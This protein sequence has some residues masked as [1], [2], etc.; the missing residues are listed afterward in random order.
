MVG[1]ES[2]AE[3]IDVLATA[4][5][6]RMTVQQIEALDLAYAPPLAPVYD[7]VLV[8]ASVAKKGLRILVRA[9]RPISALAQ[10]SVSRGA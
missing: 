8:A 1:S 5:H 2:V 10:V 4:L 7:P 6:A 3:R 9:D